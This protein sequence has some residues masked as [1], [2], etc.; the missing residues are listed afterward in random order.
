MGAKR[1]LNGTSKVNTQTDKQ[2]HIW[3][4]RHIECIGPEGRCFE[5]RGESRNI[6]ENGKIQGYR[7]KTEDGLDAQKCT[8]NRTKKVLDSL[9]GTDEGTEEEVDSRT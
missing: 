9:N 8:K 3:T 4:F 2:T 5:K 7:G 1:L 6:E